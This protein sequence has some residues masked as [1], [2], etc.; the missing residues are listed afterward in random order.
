MGAVFTED[1]GMKLYI[2]GA[3]RIGKSA[4]AKSVASTILDMA[5]QVTVQ[6][7][8]DP[9]EQ[10]ARNR[11]VTFDR[12]VT[13]RL[14][15]RA[16]KLCLEIIHAALDMMDKETK[17]VTIYNEA[18]LAFLGYCTYHGF[19]ACLTIQQRNDLIARFIEVGTKEGRNQIFIQPWTTHT[20]PVV[21]ALN[22]VIVPFATLGGNVL[23]VPAQEDRN[24]TVKAGALVGLRAIGFHKG[25]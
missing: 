6:V 24:D 23:V 13:R 10:A 15:V 4:V 14:F 18:P 19:L 16:P 21:F 5:P 1:K 17:G 9:V 3:C 7:V 20:D 2:G 8:E 22:Q 11:G 25:G 12:I